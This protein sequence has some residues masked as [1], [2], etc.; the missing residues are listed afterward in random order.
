MYGG[1]LLD[2]DRFVMDGDNYTSISITLLGAVT[3][4]DGN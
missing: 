3:T 2:G 1:Q 4:I